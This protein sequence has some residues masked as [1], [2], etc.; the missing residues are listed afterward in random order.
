MKALQIFTTIPK[1]Y[2]DKSSIKPDRVERFKAALAEAKIDPRY[3]IAHGAYVLN[4]ATP[5][6]EKSSR[7]RAGPRAGRRCAR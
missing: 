7:A 4:T 5:E 2:G 1:F 6:E 3:V